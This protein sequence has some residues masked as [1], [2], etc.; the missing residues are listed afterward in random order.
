MSL[1]RLDR[2]DRQAQLSAVRIYDELGKRGFQG[3]YSLVKQYNRSMRNDRKILA[4][5][6]CK[7]YPGKKSQIEFYEFSYMEIDGVRRKERWDTAPD[8]HEA[9]DNGEVQ[10]RGPCA[11][12]TSPAKRKRARY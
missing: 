7:T 10:Y 11:S 2:Y 3:P 12:D 4:A 9:L 6:R 8:S 5:Y 1:S